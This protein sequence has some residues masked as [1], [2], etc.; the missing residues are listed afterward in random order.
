[1]NGVSDVDIHSGIAGR[2]RPVGARSV[3]GY[4]NVPFEQCEAVK[5][6][7][8]TA[9]RLVRSRIPIYIAGEPGAGRRTLARSVARA[10]PGA[11][12]FVELNANNFDP[13][14]L[15]PPHRRTR[16]VIA[17]FPELLDSKR[18]VALAIA[19]DTRAVRLVAWGAEAAAD[20][21][22]PELRYLLEPGWVL[23]PPLRNRGRDVLRWAAFFLHQLRGEGAPR[24][25]AGAEE[26]LLQ[27][28]WPGNLRQL[29]AAL[30]RALLRREPADSSPITAE[31]LAEPPQEEAESVLPLAKAV[32][33][34]RHAYVLD[35][36]A[37]FDGDRVRTAK[38]LDV[39]PGSLNGSEDAPES[40]AP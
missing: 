38:A 33:R 9:M 16:V 36:L 39:D 15:V 31:E 29:D 20:G 19:A 1:M 27:N 2:S 26:A 28:C 6:A 13:I 8:E 21:L 34:F 11:C 5:R 18:Q 40:G 24:V 37:R 3:R 32:E 23:L 30:R 14:L 4:T 35:A 17:E 10:V 25:S 7:H 12:D 22:D